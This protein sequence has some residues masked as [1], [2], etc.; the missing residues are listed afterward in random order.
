MEAVDDEGCSPTTWVTIGPG[1]CTFTGDCGGRLQ[2]RSGETGRRSPV[3]RFCQA[4]LRR[5]TVIKNETICGCR[6][7][8]SSG[9]SSVRT[10]RPAHGFNAFRNLNWAKML[11]HTSAQIRRKVVGVGDGGQQSSSQTCKHSLIDKTL[12]EAMIA[13]GGLFLWLMQME[14]VI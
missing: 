3:C 11:C 1:V 2:A 9:A 7:H 5:H 10:P 6:G 12:P 13:K 8:A 4:V 14:V